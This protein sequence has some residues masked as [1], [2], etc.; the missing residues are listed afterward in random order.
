[1]INENFSMGLV[2]VIISRASFSYSFY[3]LFAPFSFSFYFVI[4][5]SEFSFCFR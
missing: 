2:V 3:S 4:V 5:L 1:M